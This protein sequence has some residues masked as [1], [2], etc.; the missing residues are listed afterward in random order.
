[1]P[2]VRARGDGVWQGMV[3][4]TELF[5]SPGFAFQAVDAMVTNFHLPKSSLFML[6]SALG[7]VELMKA[8]YRHAIEARYRFYSYGDC[9]LIL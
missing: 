3:G 2:R 6:V 8:A 5:I 1:M 4:E 7:G 9:M